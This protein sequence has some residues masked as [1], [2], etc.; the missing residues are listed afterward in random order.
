V[1][2]KDDITLSENGTTNVAVKYGDTQLALFH[3]PK[4]GFYATQQM[5]PHRRAF[6]LDHGIIGNTPTGD[7]YVSCPLHKRNFSLTEGKC[8]SD[9]DYQ[10]IAFEARVV[11]DEEISA[12]GGDIQLLLPPKDDIDAVLGTERWIIRQAESEALGLNAATQIEMVASGIQ[13]VG[14]KSEEGNLAG[15]VCGDKFKRLE[16]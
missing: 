14:N 11:D 10:I 4:R 1:A 15:G 8:L 12:S 16:W 6:V 2:K 9:P 5:C 7:L 13:G 3:V